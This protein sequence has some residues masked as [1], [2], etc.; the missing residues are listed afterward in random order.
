VADGWQ[1]IYFNPDRAKDADGNAEHSYTARMVRSGKP[2]YK[3]PVSGE[4]TNYR[5][6]PGSTTVRDTSGLERLA[7]VPFWFGLARGGVH[8]FVGHGAVVNEFHWSAMPD[9]PEA[10]EET[11]LAEFAWLSGVVVVPPTTWPP[12]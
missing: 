9:D 8:T 4:V 3:I 10:I 2:Y 5:P 6:A 7:K 12:R 1:A 11:P